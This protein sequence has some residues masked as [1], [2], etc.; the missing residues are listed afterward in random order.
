MARALVAVIL[1]A[2]A[3]VPPPAQAD[4][5]RGLAIAREMKARERG[6]GDSTATMKMLLVDAGGAGSGSGGR[7]RR[8][9]GLGLDPG[10]LRRARRS[11]DGIQGVSHETATLAGQESH[12]DLRQRADRGA[13]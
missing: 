6:F 9:G 7:A 10:A 1:G 13:R 12:Q 3:I 2:A 5:E 8:G 11:A 4:V